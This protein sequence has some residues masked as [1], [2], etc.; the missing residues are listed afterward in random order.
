M[1]NAMFRGDLDY[2][3]ESLL[4]GVDINTADEEGV[5]LLHEAMIVGQNEIAIVLI[6]MGANINQPDSF[7]RTAF[8]WALKN[9]NEEMT[10]YL[11]ER[12]AA[13]DANSDW[14]KRFWPIS[15]PGL[16]LVPASCIADSR[17]TWADAE[18]HPEFL[19][20]IEK[21]LTIKN[22]VTGRGEFDYPVKILFYR[23]DSEVWR[24]VSRLAKDFKL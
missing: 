18:T 13:L 8:Y 4:I 5:T 16:G 1:S 22:E 19:P 12:D 21:Y 15:L 9:R 20:Y 7:G 6:E 24:Q 3:V 10:Q 23:A 14:S 2:V 11:M 17:Q